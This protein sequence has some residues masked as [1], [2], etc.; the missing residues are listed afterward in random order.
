MRMTVGEKNHEG[1]VQN[2]KVTL[3]LRDLSDGETKMVE[4]NEGMSSKMGGVLMESKVEREET[5]EAD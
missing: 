5:I 2:T 1:V 3:V 4:T